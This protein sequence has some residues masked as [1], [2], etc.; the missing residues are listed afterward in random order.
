MLEELKKWWDNL[1]KKLGV[2]V[3]PDKSAEIDA[4]L[5]ELVTQLEKKTEP[6][7]GDKKTDGSQDITKIMEGLGKTIKDALGVKEPE[8]KEGEPKPGGLDAD[9][10]AKAITAAMEPVNKMV[11]DLK[12]QSED[13]AKLYQDKEK[14]A[15]SQK[16]QELLQTA[17]KKGKFSSAEI[18][19]Y[20]EQLEKN[21]EVS[22]NIIEKLPENAV[23]AKQNQKSTFTLDGKPAEPKTLT[24]E[25][26]KKA[27]AANYDTKWARGAKP[28]VLGFVEENIEN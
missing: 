2:S 7:E 18:A 5:K 1:L 25:E 3:P 4:A 23:V 13:M 9:A 26:K 22:K 28:D 15:A 6:P 17:Y 24:E 12:K 21:F 27:I 20:K 19:F 8:K 10:I 11:L 14:E 16:I